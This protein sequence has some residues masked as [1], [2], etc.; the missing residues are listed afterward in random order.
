MWWGG[1]GGEKREWTAWLRALLDVAAYV[2]FSGGLLV[3][4]WGSQGHKW[5]SQRLLRLL[6]QESKLSAVTRVWPL[7][8]MTND[9]RPRLAAANLHPGQ[10]F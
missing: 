10:E 8:A 7:W 6:A 4:S 1:V 5:G 9:S 2:A 3:E